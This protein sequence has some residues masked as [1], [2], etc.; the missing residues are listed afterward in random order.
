MFNQS[1]ASTL[2]NDPC[3]T[4]PLRLLVYQHSHVL[5]PVRT[6][7]LRIRHSVLSWALSKNRHCFSF[8]SSPIMVHSS[9][10]VLNSSTVP[11]VSP[12]IAPVSMFT[13]ISTLVCFF[14][15]CTS[16]AG[17][18]VCGMHGQQKTTNPANVQSWCS[19]DK[20]RLASSQHL[21]PFVY[22]VSFWVLLPFDPSKN[23]PWNCHAGF[24][25]SHEF[26]DPCECQQQV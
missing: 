10:R 5:R 4:N 20:Q 19:N 21:Q 3:P 8:S 1:S 14:L 17:R 13:A 12:C 24:Q 6:I 18:V 7:A 15:F 16:G 26:P 11:R 22:A 9:C 25:L 2:P 23:S